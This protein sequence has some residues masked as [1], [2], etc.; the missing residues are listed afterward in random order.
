[1]TA[2][3]YAQ[4]TSVAPER[5]RVE[6]ER[7]LE[8]HGATGFYYG[9]EENTAIIGF[10]MKERMIKFQLSL[11]VAGDYQLSPT[12]LKRGDRSWFN[13]WDQAKRSR[14][15]ALRLIIL[16]KLEAVECGVV[17]FEDEFMPQTMM[18]DGSTVAQWMGPQLTK[19]YAEGIMPPSMLM[20]AGPKEGRS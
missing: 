1:M 9:T 19:A 12:G 3:R 5:S 15:R 13:A 8:R 2:R 14:W 16:A 6:I 4:D 20:L 10:R 11:P 18:P 17:D 7:L